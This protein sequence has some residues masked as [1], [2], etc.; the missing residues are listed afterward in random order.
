MSVATESPLRLWTAPP[1]DHCPILWSQVAKSE[2]VAPPCQFD[3]ARLAHPLLDYGGYAPSACRG[4][5]PPG[6]I[7]ITTSASCS[8]APESCRSESIGRLSPRSS[9][10]RDSCDRQSTGTFQL[11]RQQFQPAR[12]VWKAARCGCPLGLGHQLQVVDHDQG[13]SASFGAVSGRGAICTTLVARS[14]M[15]HGRFVHLR[16]LVI[17]SQSS[18]SSS[19]TDFSRVNLPNGRQ[20]PVRPVAAGP[21]PARTRPPAFA[22]PTYG[23]RC[24][25]QSPSSPYSVDRR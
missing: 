23:R 9:T 21:S 20:H 2:M 6:N 4:N 11:P 22:L 18:S 15:L 12:D 24:S 1:A 8:M 19:R 10:F 5:T 17:R 14:S 13:P 7:R 3:S 25:S 16:R